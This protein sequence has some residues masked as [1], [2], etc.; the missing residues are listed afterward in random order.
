MRLSKPISSALLVVLW[1][2]SAACSGSPETVADAPG[3]AALATVAPG[4]NV[5]FHVPDAST[6]PEGPL[7]DAVRRGEQLA[8]HTRELL[9]E[10]VGNGLR[11]ASCHLQ[12]GK[13]AGAGPWIGLAGVFPEFRSRS[14]RINT[15]EMRVNDCFERSMNGRPLDPT[16][17]DMAALLAYIGWLSRDVPIGH[18]VEGR[19]F[20]RIASPPAPDRERGRALYANKCAVCHGANGEGKNGDDGSYQFPAL[21]GERSFNIGAGMARLDTAAAYARWNMPLGQ[22]GTLSDQEAYDVAAF[23]TQEP[24]PDF[25]RKSE[26]WP[27]GGRPRDARY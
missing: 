11:C 21:W 17:E 10:N 14:A 3:P 7:G 15:L 23:F 16:S 5:A 24:R 1:G 6:I 22:G 25:A 13:V 8:L 12:A 26:D 19:G 9:P 20:R 27:S 2:A 18:D 4:A